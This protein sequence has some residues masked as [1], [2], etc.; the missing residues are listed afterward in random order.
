MLRYKCIN[1]QFFTD[2]LFATAKVKYLCVNT[3]CQIS[4]SDKLFVA[5]YPMEIKSHFESALHHF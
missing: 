1:S 5:V 2:T 3:C 4:V